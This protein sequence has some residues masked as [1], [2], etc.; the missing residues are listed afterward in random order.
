M[1]RV[2]TSGWSYDDWAGAFYPPGLPKQSWLGYYAK[3]FRTTEI[4]STYYT[5]PAPAVVQEW[6]RKASAIRGFEYSLKIPKK[7]THDS[8]LTDVQTALDFETKVLA[9]MKSAGVLGA[10][11]V[12]LSPVLSN[13]DHLDRLATFLGVLDTKAYEYAIELRHRSWIREY[14]LDRDAK[15]LFKK[16]DVALCAVDGPS[17]PPLFTSTGRHSY[18]RLHG[19]NRDVWFAKDKNLK[20]RMNRY[21]YVYTRE[22]LEPWRAKAESVP[23][24]IRVYFNNHPHANAV[25]NAKLFEFMLGIAPE[26]GLPPVPRQTGLS[27][28]FE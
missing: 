2:G 12:Q 10:V 20:G 15:A 26:P 8:L 14:G 21:D 9:P 11:L 25:R 23:G 28:F 13:P 6:I 3:F 7:V 24:T 17:M 22:E 18:V 16:Y 5:F 4:N 19:R 27:G 1:I